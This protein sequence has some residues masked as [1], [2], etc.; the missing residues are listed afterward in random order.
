M[1]D[2]ATI[3]TKDRAIIDLIIVGEIMDALAVA[4]QDTT[5][6]VPATWMRFLGGCL[7][8]IVDQLIEG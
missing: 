8:G 3:S 5:N 4:A 1:P 6:Q 2:P 7:G